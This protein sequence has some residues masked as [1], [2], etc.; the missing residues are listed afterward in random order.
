MAIVAFGRPVQTEFGDL[1]VIGVK[2]GFNHL[3]MTMPALV[4]N[5]PPEIRLIDTRDFM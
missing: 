2:I 1:A 4:I 3:L 5:L